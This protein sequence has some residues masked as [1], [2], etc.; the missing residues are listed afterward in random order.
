MPTGLKFVHLNEY[1]PGNCHLELIQAPQ[2]APAGFAAMQAVGQQWNA[3]R[4]VRPVSGPGADM[5]H[6]RA[7][8]DQRPPHLSAFFTLCELRPPPDGT[9]PCL[10]KGL[11][12]VARM[13]RLLPG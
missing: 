8:S 3:D 4:P 1:L 6:W 11:A 9:N 10:N 13:L 2:S 5:R 12:Q 7:A